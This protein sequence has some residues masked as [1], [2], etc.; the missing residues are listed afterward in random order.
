[1]Y[2]AGEAG[3]GVVAMAS[4]L[5]GGGALELQQ[6]RHH[7]ITSPRKIARVRV[8]FGLFEL[9]LPS[10]LPTHEVQGPPS[11][12]NSPF[13]LG[14]L[15]RT[16]EPCCF[17]LQWQWVP[18]EARGTTLVGCVLS[19]LLTQAVAT[20]AAAEATLLPSV[21]SKV[22]RLLLSPGSSS[23]SRREQ[24]SCSKAAALS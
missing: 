3:S 11:G 17:P 9:R 15:E 1:M 14:G 24:R 10:Q 23:N 6:S 4:V 8:T 2:E 7:C 19:P 22:F 20:G 18:A 12:L 21:W 13:C 16:N 5:K